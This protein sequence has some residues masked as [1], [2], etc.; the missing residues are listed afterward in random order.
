MASLSEPNSKE[1]LLWQAAT[2]GNLEVVRELARDAA[3]NVNWIGPEKDDAPLHRACRFRRLE[4]FKELVANPRVDV[5]QVNV[6][7]GTAMT[8]S[9][10]VGD[11]KMVAQL[12]ADPCIDPNRTTSDGA[13]P[14]LFAAWQGHLEVVSLLLADGRSDPNICMQDGPT[15]LGMACQ[16]GRV[17]VVALLLTD[18]RVDPNKKSKNDQSSPLW[19]A[20]QNG[21]LHLVQLMLASERSIDTRI[22]SKFNGR[23]ASEQA[24]WAATQPPW[25]HIEFDDHERRRRDCPLIADLIEAYEGNPLEVRW[26]LRF[27][28]GIRER[29]TGHMLAVVVFF[30][31]GYL[32]IGTEISSSA[33]RFFALCACLPLDLQ[34][35]VCNR[36]FRSGKSVVSSR[37]SE[38]GFKWLARIHS[39]ARFV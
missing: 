21:F 3:V 14:L 9:S 2:D 8:I 37:D 16:D 18:E 26:Q 13:S 38:P 31:D 27:S 6:F 15:P 22:V 19:F 28:P 23:M 24:R 11:L 34:M 35:V 20:S 32:E 1:F 29:Y 10:F 25:S 39:S 33:K 5:T 12:L 7:G 4:V 17:A 36:M 30:S